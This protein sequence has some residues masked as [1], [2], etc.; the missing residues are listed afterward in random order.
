[1]S[2]HQGGQVK[3]LLYLVRHLGRDRVLQVII[4]GSR[5]GSFVKEDVAT[6]V[7]GVSDLRL[8]LEML[9]SNVLVGKD[10]LDFPKAR[11]I[12]DAVQR[13]PEL[14]GRACLDDSPVTGGSGEWPKIFLINNGGSGYLVA[15]DGYRVLLAEELDV[16]KA[17]WRELT[18]HP[19][20]Y[21]FGTNTIIAHSCMRVENW[22]GFLPKLVMES[23]TPAEIKSVVTQLPHVAADRTGLGTVAR[24]AAMPRAGFQEKELS[25]AEVA[26]LQ[27]EAEAFQNLSAIRAKDR[28]A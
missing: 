2:D 9:L 23:E 13:F 24:V 8:G 16:L 26:A 12:K 20:E 10:V 15:R 25:A 1:M 21:S 14:A 19:T 18:L 5:Q 7:L 27:R 28:P 11:Q 22:A 17:R 4:N 6:K 3:V